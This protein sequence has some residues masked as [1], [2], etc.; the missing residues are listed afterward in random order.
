M[1]KMIKNKGKAAGLT[2]LSLVLTAF[3]LFADVPVGQAKSSLQPGGGEVNVALKSYA[4]VTIYDGAG[5]YTDITSVSFGTDVGYHTNL[6]AYVGHVVENGDN[7]YVLNWRPTFGGNGFRLC[8]M[9]VAYRLPE[10]A[11]FSSV[12]SYMNVAGSVFRPRDSIVEWSPDGSGGCVSAG[13][14][15]TNIVFNTHLD[16]PEGS[17]IDYLRV[18]YY[19]MPKAYLPFIRR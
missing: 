1:K 2:F 17:R 14:L 11:G 10:G 5:D 7:A 13:P 6:S 9:R 16:I 4:W 19:R 12:F 3:L 15:N 18:Y 8:G